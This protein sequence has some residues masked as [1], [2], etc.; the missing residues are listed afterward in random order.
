[1]GA[2]VTISQCIKY[3]VYL[4]YTHLSVYLFIYLLFLVSQQ[5]GEERLRWVSSTKGSFDHQ[6]P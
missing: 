3:D 1:M 4:K 5:T 6:L 2:P